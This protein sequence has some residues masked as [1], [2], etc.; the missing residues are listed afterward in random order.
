MDWTVRGS[1]AGGGARLSAPVQTGPGAR[2]ASYTL[3][4]RSFPGVKRQ[5]HGVD[6]TPASSAEVK[7]RVE[8][9][10]L[11]FW[12]FVNCY[13][14]NFTFTLRIFYLSCNMKGGTDGKVISGIQHFKKERPGSAPRLKQIFK[15]RVKNAYNKDLSEISIHV[16]YTTYC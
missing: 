8:L 13:R 12:A 2:P 15:N 14:V 4:T 7:E 11:P 9:F 1:N 5:G 16:T 10:I 3:G 6:H